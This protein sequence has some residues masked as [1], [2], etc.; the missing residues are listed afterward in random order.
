MTQREA[1]KYRC[2]LNN[3]THE[4]YKEDLEI[5]S[6]YT[7]HGAKVGMNVQFVLSLRVTHKL[8]SQ[9]SLV[10][11]DLILFLLLPL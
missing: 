6:S 2:E 9:F 4:E 10:L 8:V 5:N 1:G 3:A 7:Y 11:F